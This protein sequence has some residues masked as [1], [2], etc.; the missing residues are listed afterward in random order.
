M[1]GSYALSLIRTYVPIAVGV[2]LT[3]LATH[4]GVVLDEQTSIGV[5]LVAVA[6]VAGVY[7]AIVRAFERHFPG[8]GRLL[9]SLGARGGEPVY[10]PT[11]RIRTSRLPRA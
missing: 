3:W 9:L 11:A 2:V 6:L 10:A 1:L 8:L 4:W 5:A 7:Y